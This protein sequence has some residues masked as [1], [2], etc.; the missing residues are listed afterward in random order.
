MIVFYAEVV[1]QD[2][3]DRARGIAEKTEG[4]GLVEVERLEEGDK[5]EVGHRQV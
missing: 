3:G 5:T 1:H 2:E 4:V